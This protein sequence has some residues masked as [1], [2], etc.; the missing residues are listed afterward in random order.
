MPQQT[1]P[2]EGTAVSIKYLADGPLDLV[3]T[4]LE[5]IKIT[6]P[7]KTQFLKRLACSLV[8]PRTAIVP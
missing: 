1:Y 7:A 3:W 2:W 4:I 5:K 8:T 6:I